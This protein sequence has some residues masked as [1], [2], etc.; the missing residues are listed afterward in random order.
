MKQTFSRQL[1]KY[2]ITLSYVLYPCLKLPNS[3]LM[4]KIVLNSDQ[5]A[6]KGQNSDPRT[7]KSDQ[8]IVFDDPYLVRSLIGLLP[9]P[10]AGQDTTLR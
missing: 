6:Q 10:T 4:C 3:T 1:Q 5:F 7:T 8:N 9:L 2:R